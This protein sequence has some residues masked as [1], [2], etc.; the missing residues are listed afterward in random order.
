M[1]DVPV[2]TEAELAFVSAFVSAAQETLATLPTGDSETLHR[3][4]DRLRFEVG[5]LD[6]AAGDPNDA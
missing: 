1:F 3:F 6:S 4:R 5:D 2:R